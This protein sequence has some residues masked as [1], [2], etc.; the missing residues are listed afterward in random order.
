[1]S[2]HCAL[3]AAVSSAIWFHSSIIAEAWRWTFL[4]VIFILQFYIKRGLCFCVWV[5]TTFPLSFTVRV[6]RKLQLAISE[7]GK[8]DFFLACGQVVMTANYRE[9]GVK[10]GRWFFFKSPKIL[11]FT[12]I[13]DR[14][15]VL[16]KNSVHA[17]CRDKNRLQFSWWNE[18][19]FSQATE[20]LR[21]VSQ[22]F[23]QMLG[24]IT[25]GNGRGCCLVA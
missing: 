7:N 17:K 15:Q 4:G 14:L 13:P 21:C 10:I 1:M 9:L 8:Y 18:I 20:V 19:S 16:G 25:N 22:F 12:K 24:V 6:Y 3:K 11:H 5:G 2:C 23:L